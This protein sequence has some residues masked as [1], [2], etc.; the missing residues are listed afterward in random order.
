M[1]R[2][3]MAFTSETKDASAVGSK[4]IIGEEPDSVTAQSAAIKLWLDRSLLPR[5]LLMG[6][7][8][9]KQAGSVFL[10]SHTLESTAAYKERLA[11][12]TLLNVFRKTA[13]FLAGQVFQSDIVFADDINPI[14]L[15]WAK[16]IDAAGNSI[17]VFA[18][19]MFQNGIGEGVRH[20]LID[21]PE[22]DPNVVTKADEKKAGVRPYFKDV[23]PKDV[24]GGIIDE[25]GFLIQV[26]IAETVVK[27]VGRFGTKTVNRV[28]VIEAGEWE[29][30][31]EGEDGG[32][33]IVTTGVFS[34][35]VLPFVTFIPGEEWT[36]LT[37]E[38][39]M[40]DLA[41]LNLKHWRS[42][43]DQDNYLSYCRF[44]LFFSR[45]LDLKLIAE[46]PSNLINSND[47]NADL[48]A[49]EMG[50]ASIGA[51]LADLKETEAQMA[52]YGLQQLVPR[53]GSM[54]ATE[55]ALTSAE[56][57]SSLGTWATEFESVLN[58]AFEI[59]AMFMKM[60]W[61]DN[62]LTVNKE[63]N[64][65]V[66]DPEELAKILDAKEKGILSAQACFAEFR[67]RGVFEEHLTWGDMEADMEQEKR[68]NIDMA[69]LAGAA[70]G[71][72]PGDDQDGEEDDKGEEEEEE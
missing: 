18:K 32:E 41:E 61:P 3:K 26:R 44:P 10:P 37:G 48:K 27:R 8:G 40:M 68:D 60:E 46:S 64:F 69:R 33:P 49:V 29:L 52:L 42:S 56:S 1:R 63:Y 25:N 54:T 51:G 13:S 62:G 34:A 19:R 38:T 2:F 35:N 39:P 43:S 17:D 72:A 53:T 66:A 70:F 36:I 47:K 12:S 57:N 71:D 6:T 30:H 55:K 22:K 67:R 59:A 23:D 14:F 58:K 11:K 20:I 4:V 16:A 24:L 5:T 65:G 7:Y 45:M 21:M 15:E 31:E 50:G 28:R 9:M